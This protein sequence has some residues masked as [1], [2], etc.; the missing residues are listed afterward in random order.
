MEVPR[1]EEH[2][3]GAPPNI[4]D[5]P[6]PAPDNTDFRPNRMRVRREPIIERADGYFAGTPG[7]PVQHVS[8]VDVKNLL[9][10]ALGTTDRRLRRNAQYMLDQGVLSI[11]AGIHQG[12]LGGS[13]WAPDKKAH[14]TVNVAGANY[15]FRMNTNA[16]K[17]PNRIIE[18]SPDTPPVIAG[19]F[20]VPHARR[21]P[22][23][24][25]PL[26]SMLDGVPIEQ[27]ERFVE[28]YGAKFQQYRN[29]GRTDTQAFHALLY[30][31]RKAD[32]LIAELLKTG[33]NE[34]V[35]A[36]A[37]RVNIKTKSRRTASD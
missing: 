27:K 14:I 10:K 7:T 35:L 18:I 15:H 22:P 24:E 23:A 28:R 13:G 9:K 17:K 32:P 3:S 4:E 20:V 30:N 21:A 36:N 33:I 31:F 12:G 26:K 2:L 6:L 11:T 16:R 8:A 5:A 19:G 37:E 1:V 34:P 29:R 25:S